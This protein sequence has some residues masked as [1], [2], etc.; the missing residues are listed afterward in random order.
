MQN[1]INMTISI[2]G[3][4]GSYHHQVAVEVYGKS[5]RLLFRN[6][7]K[8]VFDDVVSGQ[9]DNAVCAIENSSVG[10][11]NEVYDLLRHTGLYIIGEHY[12]RISHCL[13][14]LKGAKIGDIKAV[15]SHPMA[16]L[17]CESY[18]ESQLPKADIHERH[19][20]AQSVEYIVKLGDRSQVAIASKQSAIL[21]KAEVL[22]EDIETDK[23][24]YTRFLILQKRNGNQDNNDVNKTSIMVELADKPG[25]LY[26]ALGCFESENI[27]LT[28]LESRPILGHGWRYYFY[29]DFEAGITESRAKRA[30]ECLGNQ[31]HDLTLLGSYKKGAMS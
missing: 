14:G 13:V 30:L 28:K 21:H 12:M 8:E 5:P 11:I 22:A 7:F 20:T 29:I 19:D 26:H 18:L 16:L 9:A 23:H 3:Q 25:S 17:Q 6:N 31:G 2:Q 10:S 15:H 24:N 1:K 27:N 4:L